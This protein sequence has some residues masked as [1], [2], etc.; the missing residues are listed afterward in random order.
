M[1]KPTS[2]QLRKIK[3]NPTLL[4]QLGYRRISN[5]SCTVARVDKPDWQKE[6]LAINPAI[7]MGRDGGANYYR[8]NLSEDKIKLEDSVYKLIP[9]SD[10]DDTGFINDDGEDLRCEVALLAPDEII[11]KNEPCTMG[12]NPEEPKK[13][14]FINW[15]LNLLK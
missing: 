1:P 8:R 4:T 2:R 5:S 7:L 14:S 12:A 13:P 11:I 3:N 6:I 9:G 15:L 10:G